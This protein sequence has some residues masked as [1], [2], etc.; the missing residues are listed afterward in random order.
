[1]TRVISAVDSLEENFVPKN[2][3]F[4]QADSMIE[5]I[6]FNQHQSA[7]QNRRD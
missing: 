6:E 5:F 1:M 3:H 7:K 2:N 4:Q